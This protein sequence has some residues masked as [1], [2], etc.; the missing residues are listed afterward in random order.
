MDFVEGHGPVH[1]AVLKGGSVIV[2]EG[3]EAE[4]RM[5]EVLEAVRSGKPIREAPEGIK[6]YRPERPD[7][8]F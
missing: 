7:T 2:M 8:S 6:K 1:K 5:E 4:G 3:P